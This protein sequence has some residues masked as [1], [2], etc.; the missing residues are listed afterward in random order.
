MQKP[1][2]PDVIINWGNQSPENEK[3]WKAWVAEMIR[4]AVHNTA[5]IDD[6]ARDIFDEVHQIGYEE[7]YDSAECDNEGDG[8]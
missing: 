5:E 6:I 3:E 7:G 2:T 8:L 4:Y 1:T